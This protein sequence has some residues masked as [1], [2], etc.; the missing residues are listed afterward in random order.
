MKG[1]PGEFCALRVIAVERGPGEFLPFEAAALLLVHG[2]EADA[3]SCLVDPGCRPPEWLCRRSGR[4]EGEYRRGHAPREAAAALLR[5]AGER[6]ILIY[7]ADGAEL[8]LLSEGGGPPTPEKVL[9][10]RQ[11]AWLALPY[12]RDHSLKTLASSLLGEDLTWKAAEEVRLLCRL[13][14]YLMDAWREA[15]SRLRAAVKGAFSEAGNPWHSHL[16]GGRGVPDAY[17][18]LTETLPRMESFPIQE[19][20]LPE[21]E[22]GEDTDACGSGAERA[23]D[24]LS[25]G[26]PLS[27]LHPAYESRPQQEAMARAVAEAL[28]DS[29]F[30]VVE[31]G[32]GVGKSLAYLVPG[33]LHARSS[34]SPLIISTYTRNLQEQLYHRDL[35]TL[36]RALGTFEYALL[37]GRGNYLC[38]RKWSEWC[39]QLSRGE[40]VLPLYGLTPA[41]GYAFLSSW[42]SRSPSGDLEEISIDLRL[43]LAGAAERLASQPEDCLRSRCPF[44]SRCF[45]ERARALAATSLVVVVNHALLLSQICTSGGETSDLVLPPYRHLVVDEAHHLEEVATQ[46]FTLSFSLEEC[47]RLLEDGTGPRG[48]APL[49]EQRLEDEAGLRELREY[50]ALAERTRHAAESLFLLSVPQAL[51]RTPGASRWPEDDEARRLTAGELSLPQWDA[52][53]RDAEELAGLLSSF[54]SSTLRLRDRISATSVLEEQE[55]VLS[56]RRAEMLAERAGKGLETLTIFFLS[57]RSDDFSRHLRWAEVPRTAHA[58]ASDSGPRLKCAP[59]SVAESLAGLLFRRLDAAVFTSAS[60]RTT[61]ERKGFSFFLRRTGLD[62][63]EGEGR[64]VRLL[65]VDSPFDYARR[66][67]L[68]AVRDLPEPAAGPAA[69]SPYLDEICRVCGEVIRAVGGRTLVLL[70]SHQQIAYLRSRL[71]PLLESEGIACLSQSRDL[72]NALVLER[73]REDRDSV[74]LATEAFWEGVDVPGESLSA[75]IMAKLP[76]RHPGDPVVAGRVEDL[77]RRGENGWRSYYLPLALTLFRQGIGRLMRRSTDRGVVVV[78]DPRFLKRSYSYAFRAALPTGMRV[79]VVGKEEA[80]EAV[81]RFFGMEPP[82]PD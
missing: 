31:A 74:L 49:W 80:G 19:V 37:K 66:S 82:P 33:V 59:V 16:P 61:G 53:R 60:L 24:F 45:V 81:R 9:E 64:E 20:D 29:A 27:S 38:L 43:A 42:M 32:T 65:A 54:A 13:L 39:G 78:L 21:P 14:Q 72:P 35:P 30:L 71:G 15:P 46:A 23:V 67:L 41:E 47:L 57:P 63:M 36:S 51:E 62:K 48:L 12:L 55:L 17:P 75:V 10:L 50:L 11:L 73:F 76:F 6:P 58:A 56:L 22:N 7:A 68:L 70:T 8:A 34:G 3:F 77:E 44:Q 25:A 52:A 69:S 18:D 79:E 5:F 4:E 2:R 26:G 40:P 28:E 1:V